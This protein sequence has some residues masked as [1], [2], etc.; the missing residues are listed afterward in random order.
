M[1]ESDATP[2]AARRRAVPDR[3]LLPPGPR[4][5]DLAR[6][7][8]ARAFE[9]RR[10]LGHASLQ[11]CAGLGG[12][13]AALVRALARARV[14]TSW[15]LHAAAVVWGWLVLMTIWGFGRSGFP[16]QERSWLAGGLLA[17]VLVWLAAA[18]SARRRVARARAVAQD[19]AQGR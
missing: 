14:A 3:L 19:S 6:R 12:E 18:V 10:R 9:D 11:G 8:E 16:A 5:P 4:D 2:S 17:G 13:D 15:R 1:D 7:W